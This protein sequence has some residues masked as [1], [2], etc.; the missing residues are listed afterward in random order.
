MIEK[1]SLPLLES[2]RVFFIVPIDPTIL[3][4]N[5]IYLSLQKDSSV[6]SQLL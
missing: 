3:R 4:K 6:N 5:T 1:N 2:Q